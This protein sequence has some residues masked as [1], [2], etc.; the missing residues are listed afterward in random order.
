MNHAFDDSLKYL[1]DLQFFGMKLGLEN[2]RRLCASLDHPQNAFP[3][4]HVAGTNGKGSTCAMLASIFQKA[5][6]QTGLYTSPHIHHF[7]ERIR[8]NGTG[9]SEDAIVRLTQSMRPEID[10]LQCTFFEA[11][12]A[13]A[14]QYFR[15]QR[16]D[17]AVIETGLGGRLDATNVITPEISVITGIGL[18]HTEHLGRDKTKIA[19]EKGGIIKYKVPLVTGETDP[20]CLEVFHRIAGELRTDVI[21][22]DR[23]TD[24][25]NPHSTIYG[26][27][28]DV[29]LKLPDIEPRLIQLMTPMIGE[30]QIHNAV[31]AMLAALLQKRLP[32]SDDAVREGLREAVFKGRMEWLSPNI[33]TD[34]AHNPAALEALKQTINRLFRPAFKKIYLIIGM[35]SDKDYKLG[36]E[37]LSGVAD[38]FFTVTPDN[39]RAL[40]STILAQQLKQKKNAVTDCDSVE[41][42]VKKAKKI[43]KPDDLLIITGSHYVLS[44]VK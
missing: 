2:I 42:A 27:S 10:R 17:I 4:I 44:E 6:Y 16:V 1:Y 31:T 43:M 41:T 7:S 39:P 13:M 30:Y 32:V 37:I 28:F 19:A 35:L 36:V 22:A 15:E 20:D 3:T 34:A 26:S 23:V 25:L 21:R 40:K 18:D 11:T 12:T 8:V 14:F 29:I 24:I 33:I 9:I 38:Q 5:G